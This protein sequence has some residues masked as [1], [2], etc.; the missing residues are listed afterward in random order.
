MEKSTKIKTM[1]LDIKLI[2]KID[3]LAKQE[4][5]NFTNMVGTILKNEV[6]RLDLE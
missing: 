4:N 5:R 1:R 2:E 3:F 6:S